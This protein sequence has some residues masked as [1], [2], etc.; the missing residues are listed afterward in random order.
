MWDS[1]QSYTKCEQNHFLRPFSAQEAPSCASSQLSDGTGVAGDTGRA[2]QPRLG[3][4][5]EVEAAL[6]ACQAPALPA[7]RHS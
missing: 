3:Q 5:G 2:Q 6:G 7:H 4:N 1:L